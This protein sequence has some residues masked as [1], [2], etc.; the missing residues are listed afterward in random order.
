MTSSGISFYR[1]SENQELVKQLKPVLPKQVNK[2]LESLQADYFA[3]YF[4]KTAK[5]NQRFFQEL[6]PLSK[7]LI[8][9]L[10]KIAAIPDGEPTLIIAPENLW[11]RI[12]QIVQLSFPRYSESEK[13]PTH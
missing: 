13:I 1:L 10:Q 8:N 9:S 6:R 3:E 4:R 12:A 11:P 7:K 2:I 5:T